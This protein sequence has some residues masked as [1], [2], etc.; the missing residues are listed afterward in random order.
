M[1]KWTITITAN[2]SGTGIELGTAETNQDVIDAA[3]TL[4][5]YILE[6]YHEYPG[7]KRV[8]IESASNQIIA[9][10]AKR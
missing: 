6:S 2:V 9:D 4:A 8:T 10:V 5:R 7:F 3:F 1:E